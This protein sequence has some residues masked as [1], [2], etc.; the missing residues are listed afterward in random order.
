MMVS[1]DKSVLYKNIK[2]LEG[3]YFQITSHEHQEF[4]GI[5][6][7]FLQLVIWC[8]CKQKLLTMYFPELFWA[9]FGKDFDYSV[10]Y[11]SLFS[12]SF[13][14]TAH[15]SCSKNSIFLNL[16]FALFVEGQAKQVEIISREQSLVVFPASWPHLGDFWS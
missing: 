5:N 1:E 16:L 10:I 3:G 7:L 15:M 14:V 11:F 2:N 9:L 12:L 8:N 13:D 4:S 6:F